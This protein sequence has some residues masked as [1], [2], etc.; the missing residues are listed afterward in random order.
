[1]E[2]HDG[3]EVGVPRTVNRCTLL[4]CV[5]LDGTRVKPAIITKN[6]T[7]NSL[8]F[9]SGYSPENVTVYTTANSFITCEVF[10]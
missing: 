9:E 10:M 3:M 5:G 2:H 4:G 8:I 7:L 1:M 6:K